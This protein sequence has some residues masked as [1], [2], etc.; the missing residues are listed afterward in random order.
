MIRVRLLKRF[1]RT[2]ARHLAT[3]AKLHHQLTFQVPS[4]HYALPTSEVRA[5][6]DDRPEACREEQ[7]RSGRCDHRGRPRPLRDNFGELAGLRCLGNVKAGAV[8]SS[9]DGT[10]HSTTA[11]SVPHTAIVFTIP[12]EKD[13]HGTTLSHF[14][15]RRN[16]IGPAQ[17]PGCSIA[18]RV[19]AA[20]TRRRWRRSIS[21][22]GFAAARI[23]FAL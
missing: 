15:V 10:A 8:P 9:T 16:L 5:S 4:D 12:T 17:D 3:A 23:S 14:P 1:R 7:Q 22:A 13:G 11:L 19:S 21:L 20:R 6:V 18:V 2:S